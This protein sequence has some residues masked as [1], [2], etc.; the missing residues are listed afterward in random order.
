MSNYKKIGDRKDATKIRN[1][2]GMHYILADLKP[3]RCDADV[4]INQKFDVT[5][6]IKYVE[7]KKKENPDMKITYFH[8]FS[9]AI[10][11]LLYNRPYMN[12]FVANRNY[13]QR[14]KVKLSFVAKVE[15][16]DNS[17][18]LLCVV[19]VLP[20]YT[21][22]DIAKFIAARVA[23]IRNN[24]KSDTNDAIDIIGHLPKI[25]RVPIVGLFKWVDKHGWLPDSLT[26]DNIY[27][28]SVILSNLG[29]IKCGSIYHN[30]TN[31]GTNSILATMGQ[32]HKEEVVNE[33]RKKEI[34]DIC[35]FGVNLDER[36]ADGVY[37]AK[38]L[39]LLQYMFDHPEILDEKVSELIDAK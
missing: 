22:L 4:Y 17:E 2:D 11:K 16:E 21:M 33:K 18:E 24:E 13:Y 31:F 36:I 23:S 12:R 7:K 3:D 19:N 14:D 26:N 1:L 37:F 34:R 6:L 15:F 10:A 32:I 20:D 5:N 28:S 9:T 29:S 8:A 25:L 35:D 27:Y 30:L 38:S 39:N